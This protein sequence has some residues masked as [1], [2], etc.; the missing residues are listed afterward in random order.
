MN[1]TIPEKYKSI[2]E[3]INSV[4]REINVDAFIVGGFVRDLLL[5]R[6]PNDLDIMI[7]PKTPSSLEKF[8]GINF[9]KTLSKKYVLPI[10]VFE[11]F[12]TAKLNIEN[13]EVE[14]IM[15]RKEI[16]DK[17]SRN[18]QTFPAS[19]QEDAFRRDFT[20]N[21]LFLKIDNLEIID[22]TSNGLQDIEN[23]LIRVTIAG[24]EQ[25]IFCEDPLRILRAIRQSLQLDFQ[26]ESKTC[27]AM[28][29]AANK[30]DIVSPDQIRDELNKILIVQNPSKAFLAMDSIGLLGK[31]FPE[32]SKLKDIV[33]P[34]KYHNVDV[35]C[36]TLKVV[37]RVGNNLIL[38]MA[39][40]LCD[41]GKYET[42]NLKDKTITFY[43]HEIIGAKLAEIALKRLNYQKDFCL[44]VAEIIKNHLYPKMYND[45]WTDAAVRRFL[46][47]CG[48]NLGLILKISKADYGKDIGEEKLIKLEN[49]IEVLKNKNLLFP[50][51]ELLNGSELIEIFKKPA[52][53][54]IR[55]AKEKVNEMLIENPTLTKEEII[56]SLKKSQN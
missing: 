19:L 45:D 30:I 5:K 36:H 10:S 48:D 15:P 52:G 22:L 54:W 34:K 11:Q 42:F 13:E 1:L 18:P 41:I 23:K 44:K 16:Y 7:A 39:A 21:A 56:K 26:I 25:R 43:K 17:N 49:R 47:R 6:E 37:D 51:E 38:R 50:K 28:K 8:C 20:V 31:I 24:D 3:K 27:E 40:L 35:F 46:Q 4:A 2:I 12:G 32:L 33:Q 53:K 55:F 9:A 29:F 14:F